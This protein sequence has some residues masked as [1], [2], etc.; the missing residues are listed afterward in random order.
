MTTRRS[1]MNLGNS[2]PSIPFDKDAQNIVVRVLNRKYY[3]LPYTLRFIDPYIEVEFNMSLRRTRL[4]HMSRLCMLCMVIST[5]TIY[6]AYNNLDHSA[7]VSSVDIKKVNIICSS[8][9]FGISI[10]VIILSRLE[11]VSYMFDWIRFYTCA[12]FLLTLVQ[13]KLWIDFFENISLHQV[14]NGLPHNVFFNFQTKSNMIQQV[15]Y[16]SLPLLCFILNS[17]MCVLYMSI[18]NFIEIAVTLSAYGFLTITF[19]F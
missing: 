3:L 17:F 16:R 10:M 6:F 18:L 15:L 11:Q 1:L 9:I 7:K 2:I 8:C 12:V 13:E 14:E 19:S 4:Q 5:H